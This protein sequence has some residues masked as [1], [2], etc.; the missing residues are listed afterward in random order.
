MKI[1][2][3]DARLNLARW[4]EQ[5]VPVVARYQTRDEHMTFHTGCR[6]SSVSPNLE[7]TAH[8]APWNGI[9]MPDFSS[10]HQIETAAWVFADSSEFTDLSPEH[11]A[12]FGNQVECM[13]AEW[14]G[15]EILSLYLLAPMPD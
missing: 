2:P 5:H 11:Q 7:L 3:E 14:P 8:V 6:V 12:A 15:G 13:G 9:E 4:S 1:S 10:S